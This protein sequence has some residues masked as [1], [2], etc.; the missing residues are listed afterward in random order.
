MK[1]IYFSKFYLILPLLCI[2]FLTLTLS[3]CGVPLSAP[4]ITISVNYVV[5]WSSVVGAG[6]YEVNLNDHT[7]TTDNTSFDIS[8]YLS[9]GDYT[10]KVKA[11][12]ASGSFFKTNSEYSNEIKFGFSNEKMIEPSNFE[13]SVKNNY[14]ILSWDYALTGATFNIRFAK[15]GTSN[16]QYVT[17]TESPFDLTSYFTE[18]GSYEISIRTAGYSTKQPSDYVSSLTINFEKQL[19]VPNITNFSSNIVQ[20]E[21]VV[22][23][24]GYNVTILG[25]QKSY[26]TSNTT[27]DIS[28]FD[29]YN[30]TFNT[31][32]I[33]SVGSESNF[34]KNSIFSDG[35]VYFNEFNTTK[36]NDLDLFILGQNFDLYVDTQN[37]LDLL[38]QYLLFYRLNKIEFYFASSWAETTSTDACLQFIKYAFDNY[39]E[40]S[41]L[42]RKT[43]IRSLGTLNKFI[44]EIDYFNPAQPQTVISG[45]YI[46]VQDENTQPQSYPSSNNLRESDYNNFA[47]FNSTEWANVYTGEQLFQVLQQ[48]IKPIFVGSESAGEILFDVACEILRKIC[49]DS[50]S[51]YQKVK[52]IY[53]WICFNNKY[54]HN[55]ADFSSELESIINSVKDSDDIAKYSKQLWNCRAFYLEGMFLDD[56]QAVC[57]GIAK[58]F[59]TL[60]NIEGISCY[61][62]N[63]TA[64][65]KSGS[66]TTTS[67][68]AWNKVKISNI[69]DTWYTV[70]CTWG[71]NWSSSANNP[72]YITEKLAY[73]YFMLND[74]IFKNTSQNNYHIESYPDKDVASFVNYNFNYNNNSYDLYTDTVNELSAQISLFTE[75]E[76]CFSIAILSS[77]NF[78]LKSYLPTNWESDQLYSFNSGLKTYYVYMIYYKN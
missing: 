26:F 29:N 10:V 57:D 17:A 71:D 16:Y 19:D 74:E 77:L 39:P 11:I 63:G 35:Y 23:A 7:Y 64:V 12:P 58:A 28:K 69:T 27:V 62:V 22:G 73:E 41:S 66:S 68:H 48:G 76:N 47:I 14:V 21:P 5:S 38:I 30:E 55:T 72:N 50:M 61:K 9:A 25:S 2:I 6:S 8:P 53:E 4:S 37:E 33:Q 36:A 52:A 31:I 1:S 40:I 32:Y 18:G 56:G 24:S 75:Q 51:D 70:D 78:M 13:I 54:D 59:S 45:D 20:W 49:T 67:G 65:Q 15:T 60:C 46:V 34:T 43:T 44:L 42:S 3:A